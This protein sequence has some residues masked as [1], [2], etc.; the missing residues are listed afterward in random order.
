MEPEPSN[1]NPDPDAEQDVGRVGRGKKRVASIVE[2]A[3]RTGERLREEVPAIDAGWETL[4]RDLD[5]G[6][7]IIS[8]AV[9]FRMFL[10]LL[11]ATLVGV[12]GFGLLADSAS[13]SPEGLAK[14]AGIKGIAA[15]SIAS[16]TKSSTQN[17][18][19]LIGLGIVA[20]VS[21][22][23]ALVK[24]LWRSHEM[25]WRAPERRSPSLI[26]SVAAALG[27]TF[28]GLAAATIVSALRGNSA[29]IGIGAIAIVA[30]AWF[31]LWLLISWLLPHGDAP[32]TALVP[33]AVL[34]GVSIEALRVVT[35]YYIADKVNSSSSLY[36]GLGAAAALLTWFYML[37]RACVAAAVL[38]ATLWDRRTRGESNAFKRFHLR[39][40]ASSNGD[41]RPDR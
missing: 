12:V 5:T 3:E 11:P 38:N 22:T 37:S 27:L 33:G 31:G 4:I 40:N 15:G 23:K 8:G 20:L 36:G 17:R 28:L 6:G 21:A 18:W 24:V 34:V 26:G 35:I 41:V 1:E 25:A 19:L 7:P 16:A 9:A 30:M 32:W 2:T 10:W 29:V 39:G 13:Q 14:S